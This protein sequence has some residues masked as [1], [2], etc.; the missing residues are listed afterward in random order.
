[1]SNTSSATPEPIAAQALVEDTSLVEPHVPA[2]SEHD[3]DMA[4]PEMRALLDVVDR[5]IVGW[6]PAP[7]DK[8]VGILADVQQA[9]GKRFGNQP[10][11]PYPLVVVQTPT[12]RYIGVHAFHKVAKNQVTSMMDLGTMKIG[13]FIAVKYL[14]VAE[15]D[16]NE[17]VQYGPDGR[18]M[19]QPNLYRFSCAPRP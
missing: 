15:R 17:P 4:T 2:M 14:G 5:E 18:E 9:V 3:F 11:Q 10:P 13:Y 19:S 8:L 1:M 12:G 16:P 7:G 6:R